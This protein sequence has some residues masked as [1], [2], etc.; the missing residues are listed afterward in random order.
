MTLEMLG[1][2]M[3]LLFFIKKIEVKIIVKVI[4]RKK[5]N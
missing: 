4:K 2:S 1:G 3:A 5:A